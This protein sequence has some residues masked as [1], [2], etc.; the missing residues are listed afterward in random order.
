[1]LRLGKERDELKVV[2][3]QVGSPTYA[4]DLAAAIYAVIEAKE[5]QPGIY[6]FTSEGVC[7]WYDFTVEILRQAGVECKVT[8][9][10]SSEYQYRTPRPHS[11]VLDK[12]KIKSTFGI[13]IPYWTDSLRHC[14][15]SL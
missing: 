6:H 1:M 9:I 13:A 8:P 4:L 11:S 7:S 15:Q 2:Y 14:L 12:V 10:L 5:W 3:D